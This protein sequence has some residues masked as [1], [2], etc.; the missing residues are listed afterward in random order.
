M[1][2]LFIN[3][4]LSLETEKHMNR[5]KIFLK[6]ENLAVA[7]MTGVIKA[8]TTPEGRQAMER[9]PRTNPHIRGTEKY[10]KF[11]TDEPPT[12]IYWKHFKKGLS[13]YE[14]GRHVYMRRVE[15]YDVDPNTFKDVEQLVK[16]TWNSQ[17]TGQGKDARNLK[18]SNLRVRKV[19]RIENLQLYDKYARKRVEFFH[20]QCSGRKTVPIESIYKLYP[21]AREACRPVL[22]SSKISQRMLS[23]VY[24]EINE[25][26]L[27]HGTKKEYEENI[28]KS[29]FDTRH[30]DDTAMFGQGIY[31][32]ESST[33]ADQYAGNSTL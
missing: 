29:G 16:K 15:R 26:Y 7:T 25:F 31:A 28:T 6:G 9:K 8:I 4:F 21:R 20:R 19:E 24:P 17:F 2:F 3:V 5:M 30:G 14:M 10:F 11:L 32:A 27:F 23:D 1:S 22:I 18:H 33:K 13:F 12:P